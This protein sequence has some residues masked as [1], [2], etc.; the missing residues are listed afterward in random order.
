MPT[1]EAGSY[2]PIQMVQLSMLSIAGTRD[3]G[4]SIPPSAEFEILTPEQISS[5]VSVWS[6]PLKKNI[7]CLIT[8]KA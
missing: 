1:N 5:K 6:H 2:G 3:L 4:S 8:E 7:G